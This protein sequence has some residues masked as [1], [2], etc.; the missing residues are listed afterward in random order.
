[1]SQDYIIGSTLAE[2]GYWGLTVTRLWDQ[3]RFLLASPCIYNYL[4]L[5]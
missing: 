2:K 3:R 4:Y 5:S 1:M